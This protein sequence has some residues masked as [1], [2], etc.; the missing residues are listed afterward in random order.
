M[1][2]LKNLPLF[3]IISLVLVACLDSKTQPDALL[4]FNRPP[5]DFEIKI[6]EG[7]Q[8]SSNKNILNRCK[9]KDGPKGAVAAF[10]EK[11][12]KGLFTKIDRWTNESGFLIE[13]ALLNYGGDEIFVTIKQSGCSHYGQSIAVELDDNL[14]EE[15]NVSKLVKNLSAILNSL[16]LTN[17]GK[18]LVKESFALLDKKIDEKTIEKNCEKLVEK[19]SCSVY[20]DPRNVELQI[21]PKKFTLNYWFVL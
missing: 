9:G 11:D 3:W 15:H 6:P 2:I 5:K 21:W 19:M 7:T 16:P 1:N 17:F 14:L 18:K 20:Q 10:N 13:R 12:A 8:I 4:N